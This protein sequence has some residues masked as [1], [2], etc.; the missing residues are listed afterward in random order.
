MYISITSMTTVLYVNILATK[1]R[2][3]RPNFILFCASIGQQEECAGIV[4]FLASDE[5]SYITAET[6][7]V[8]GGAHARL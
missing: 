2:A 6:V 1:L 4:A 8:A 5:A 7:V 3:L